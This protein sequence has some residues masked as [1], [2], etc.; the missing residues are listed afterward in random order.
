MTLLERFDPEPIASL[1]DDPAAIERT[2]AL[3]EK[4]AADLDREDQPSE[5]D[6]R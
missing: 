1:L 4:A 2:R 6:R 3:L 5:N